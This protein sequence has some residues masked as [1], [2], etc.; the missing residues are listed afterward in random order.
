[1]VALKKKRVMDSFFSKFTVLA[2]K[3]TKKGIISEVFMRVLRHFPEYTLR[4][5][6]PH[7]EFFWSVFSRIRTVH[8]EI[9]SVSPYSVQMRENKDQKNSE[10]GHFSRSDIFYRTPLGDYFCVVDK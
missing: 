8:G 3:F 10:Y 1:M 4:E 6:C 2:C 5:K 7:S 9:Q